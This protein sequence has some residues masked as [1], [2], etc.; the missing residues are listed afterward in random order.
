[1]NVKVVTWL[2]NGEERVDCENVEVC[3]LDFGDVPVDMVW[4]MPDGSLKFCVTKTMEFDVLGMENSIGAFMLLQQ[5]KSRN[6]G[7]RP[8]Y[9][10]HTETIVRTV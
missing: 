3:R 6:E 4:D 1:M 8:V 10:A 5:G 9:S 2:G 7:N